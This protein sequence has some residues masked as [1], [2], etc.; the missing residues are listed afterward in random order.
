MRVYFGFIFCSHDV[1][2][3]P[4]PAPKAPVSSNTPSGETSFIDDIGNGFNSAKEAVSDK[5]GLGPD[6]P[7]EKEVEGKAGVA[8]GAAGCPT[9]YES[10]TTVDPKAEIVPGGLNCARAGI[11]QFVDQ[12][13]NSVGVTKVATAKE[14]TA[15]HAEY[16]SKWNDCQKYQSIA[17]TVCIADNSESLSDG[18]ML[19][20]GLLSAGGAAS[21]YDSCTTFGKAM[22]IGQ[23]ALAAYTAA[24]TMARQPC[25]LFC[26]NVK[27]ALSKLQVSINKV[28]PVGPAAKCEN[29]GSAVPATG[30]P[31]DAINGPC[32]ATYTAF[33]NTKSN[34]LSAI[35]AELDT[36]NIK[37][38]GGKLTRCD[39]KYWA[40]VASA[41]VGILQLANSLKK[42]KEC[43]EESSAVADI[44]ATCTIAA[45]ANLPE[46][47]CLANPRSAGCTNGLSQVG[48][49]NAGSGQIVAGKAISGDAAVGGLGTD[50][51]GMSQADKLGGSSGDAGGIGAPTGGGPSLGSIGGGSGGAVGE[52]GDGKGSGLNTDILSGAGGGG[53]GG[54]YGGRGSGDSSGGKGLRNYLPGGA[55]DPK[56]GLAGQG[57]GSKEVTGQAGKSNWEK[58]RD[59]YIDNKNSLIGN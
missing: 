41:G 30:T 6:K 55:K 54:G 4:A 2:E 8:Q 32:L 15:S 47:I 29:G 52:K 16:Q 36:G 21:V 50:S 1:A 44:Q 12:V 51:T 28:P 14:I 17:A 20:N 49:L 48:E 34:A 27:E 37:A 58:V 40:N 19:I 23:K 46:C 24:C 22:D 3:P 9:D 43:E 26:G 10:V 59:R 35:Q 57:V 45:N 31:A 18:I 11:G 53:G 25:V 33:H 7:V 42:G 13:V 38:T 5:L 39:R 56:R